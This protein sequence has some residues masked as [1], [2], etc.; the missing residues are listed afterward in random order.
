MPCLPAAAPVRLI[1]NP[2]AGGGRAARLVAEVEGTLRG[3]GATVVTT[4]TTSIAHARALAV[5]AHA[6]GALPVTLSGD[7]LVGCVAGALAGLG[8]DEPPLMGVLPGGRGNDFARMVGIPSEVREA[9]A[10]VLDGTPTPIDLGTVDGA[11][12]VGIASLGFDSDA[13]RIANDG[14]AWLGSLVYAYAALRAL[15]TYRHATFTVETDGQPRTFTGWSVAVANGSTYGGGMILAPG[16]RLDDGLLDVVLTTATSRLR[17]LRTLPKIFKGAHVGEPS[18]ELLRGAVVRVSADRP[19]VVY[20]DGDPIGALPASI[21]VL[22]A[23]VR[24]LLPA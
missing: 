9:A 14:P 16:A 23:A 18:I 8:A 2:A 4:R 24:V 10:L 20:A 11:P 17:F 7:G 5:E 15:A 12:F 22:P 19:F 13:N 1:V 3:R 6:A 21:G